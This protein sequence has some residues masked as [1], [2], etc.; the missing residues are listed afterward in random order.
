ME[1]QVVESTKLGKFVVVNTQIVCFV[2]GKDITFT[3]QDKRDVINSTLLAQLSASKDAKSYAHV[4]DWLDSFI[5][6]AAVTGWALQSGS[7]FQS[8]TAEQLHTS[9]DVVAAKFISES[10][11]AADL[12]I[13]QALLYLRG[14]SPVGLNILEENGKSKTDGTFEFVLCEKND[15]KQLVIRIYP[16]A[17]ETSE[18]VKSNLLQRIIKS[19]NYKMKYMIKPTIAVLNME[20]Y[21]RVRDTVSHKLE[22]YV[23][24]LVAFLPI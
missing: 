7:T 18:E 17:F 21:N 15:E 10:D 2:P 8:A 11:H 19:D 24:D 12:R 20:V 16:Y 9:I 14:E 6:V 1:Q 3:D 4:A 22:G 13:L 23:D 5:Q